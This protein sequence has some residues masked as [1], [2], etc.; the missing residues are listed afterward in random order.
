MLGSNH[1]HLP[2][3]QKKNPGHGAPGSHRRFGSLSTADRCSGFVSW[4][5]KD[6]R[7]CKGCTDWQPRRGCKDCRGWRP[8]K[9]CKGWRQ[10][11]DW[12][13]RDC[14]DWGI[15]RC[16]DCRPQSQ[17]HQ[18]QGR[19]SCRTCRPSLRKVEE[20]SL[21]FC[22]FMITLFSSRCER[23]KPHSGA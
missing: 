22:C 4:P 20:R 5:C 17:C 16:R 15:R 18:H 6:C 3:S 7:D 1:E 2:L 11:K 19:Q 12:G 9:D 23:Q 8:R 10:H 21:D 14:K 13:N